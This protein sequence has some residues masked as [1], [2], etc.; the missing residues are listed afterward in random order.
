MFMGYHVSTWY[1]ITVLE[2]KEKGVI[3]NGY[4]GYWKNQKFEIMADSSYEAQTKLVPVVQATTRKKVKSH[5]IAVMLAEKNGQ[6]VTHLP[7]M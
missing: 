2:F 6:Q 7:L 3:M 1:P 4:I 5:E